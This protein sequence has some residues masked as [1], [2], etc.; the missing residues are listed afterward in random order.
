MISCFRC[1]VQY[2]GET[3]KSPIDRFSGQKTVMKSPFADNNGNVLSKHFSVSLSRK[4]NY[5]VNIIEKISGSG[6][7]DN[8]ISIHGVTAERQKNETKWTLNF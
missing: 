5:I 4:A 2:F 1:G 8:G 3:I 7:D 6:R